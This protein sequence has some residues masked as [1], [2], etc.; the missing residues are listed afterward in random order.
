MLEIHQRLFAS[1]LYAK[2]QQ[3]IMI[4]NSILVTNGKVVPKSSLFLT[5]MGSN[6]GG[7]EEGKFN[8]ND[9]LI[10]CFR[11]KCMKVKTVWLKLF[12]ERDLMRSYLKSVTK[13]LKVLTVL[14]GFV[15]KI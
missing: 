11:K 12:N 9:K 14:E 10:C 6:L 13:L 15:Q 7:V 8:E 3:M 1:Q 2:F 4:F 5:K